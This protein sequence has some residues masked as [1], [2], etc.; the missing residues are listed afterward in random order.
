MRLVALAAVLSLAGTACEQAPPCADL[1]V[2]LG[3]IPPRTPEDGFVPMTA[4]SAPRLEFGSQAS[5]MLVLAVKLLTPA[6]HRDMPVEAWLEDAGGEPL[7]HAP[8]RTRPV[9]TTED[10][11]EYITNIFLPLDADDSVTRTF[12][13]DGTE[14]NLHVALGRTCGQ[15]VNISMPIRLQLP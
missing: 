5:W 4:A 2:S 10:G 13:W 6:Q 7:S 15:D 12:G 11:G 1:A 8:R 3:T 9:S 14:V